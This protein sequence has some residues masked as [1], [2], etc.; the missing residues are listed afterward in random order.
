MVHRGQGEQVR[1]ARQVV[2]DGAYAAHPE[3]FVHKRPEPPALP[4][5][6]WINPP[7]EVPPRQ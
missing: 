3:R 5:A 1:A 6:V 4:N 7:K 2:L